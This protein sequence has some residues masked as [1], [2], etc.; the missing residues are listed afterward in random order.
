MLLV[1]I[2]EEIL[3]RGVIARHLANIS[4]NLVT[5]L[6]ST[7][8]FTIFHCMVIQSFTQMTDIFFLGLILGILYIKSGHILYSIAFHFGID[9]V[10]NLVGIRGQSAL[11]LIDSNKGEN[12]ITSQLF[13]VMSLFGFLIVLVYFIYSLVSKKNND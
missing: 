5:V 4:G 6:V 7:I 2:T 1:A 3:F 13:G 8:I 10:T 12:Y 9:F 11:F